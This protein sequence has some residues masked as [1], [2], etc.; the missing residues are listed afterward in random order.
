MKDIVDQNWSREFIILKEAV[1][2]T[3]EAFVTI[4]ED[5]QVVFFNK[6]AE[7]IFGY[8][9]EDILGRDLNTILTPHCSKGHRAAVRRYLETK[10][11]TLIGHE[12]EFIAARKDGT[13]FPAVISFS[14]AE[15][16]GRH[17]FTALVRDVTEKRI[18]EEQVSLSHRLAALGQV[19]A[20]ITHE[21]KNP[22]M[23]IGGFARQLRKT[24]KD[25]KGR[26]KLGII[27]MEVERLERLVLELRDL[28]LPATLSVGPVDIHEVIEEVYELTKEECRRQRVNVRLKT[29][30]NKYLVPGDREKLKQV[31]LNLIKNAVE[32]LPGGGNLVI[33][34]EFTGE[35]I[36]VAIKDDG[37][38]IAKEDQ[39]KIFAPFF[40][41]KK[42][43][44]GLGLSI[45]KRI[46]DE[47]KG[48]YFDLSSEEGKG[49]TAK[50]SFPVTPVDVSPKE[51]L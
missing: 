20:E 11:A 47:H 25:E 41:T 21:I 15:V 48:C 9:R 35:R 46:M 30:G 42:K 22:L 49:T 32:A 39:E 27:S 3:N 26:E 36:E 5:H 45:C 37:P 24:V 2:N 29:D 7:S 19:V 12:T 23:L 34:S 44:S 50:I 13:T 38:G 18:L 17:F 33:L 4:D 14:V 1:E 10:K 6:V 8:K 43:G 28:Y 51:V 31:L 16:E 40:T